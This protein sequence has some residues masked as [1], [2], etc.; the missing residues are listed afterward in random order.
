MKSRMI[1]KKCSGDFALSPMPDA[2]VSASDHEGRLPRVLT[3]LSPPE[4][5]LVLSPR[6]AEWSSVETESEATRREATILQVVQ[7]DFWKMV[8]A[9]LA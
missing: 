5:V 6:A 7:Y 4:A 9:S 2:R 1:L 8:D 3:V